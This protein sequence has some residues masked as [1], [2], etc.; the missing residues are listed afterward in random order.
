MEKLT[1][2][3]LLKKYKSWLSAGEIQFLRKGSPAQR[4]VLIHITDLINVFS[5]A[6]RDADRDKGEI[7]EKLDWEDTHKKG[8][9]LWHE[10]ASHSLNHINSDSKGN[11]N[12][13]DF[14]EAATEFED[15]LYGLEHYYRDHTLHSLW[16]YFLGEYILRELLPDIHTNLNWYLFNDIERN[17]SD[18]SK[19]LVDKASKREKELNKEI[20]KHKD[21]TWCLMALCHDLGYS[22]AKFDKLNEKVKTV[23]NFFDLPDFKHIGYSLDVEHQYLVK[24]FLELMAID[25]R[26]VPN[27]DQKEE[28]IKCYRD[29]ATYWQ[30]CRALEKKQHGI[31]SSY[32][33]FKIL[34]I[35]ADTSV[36][37]PAEEWG[38]DDDEVIE[39]VIRGDILFGI[40]Q[41]TFDFAY[42][43]QLGSLAEILILADELEEFSR[44]GRKMLSRKY[45]DTMAETKISFH[46]E[47]PKIGED[48]DIHITYEV[49]EHHP[50][51]VF[52]KRKAEQLCKTYSLEQYQQGEKYCSIKSIKLTAEKKGEKY[53]FQLHR[54]SKKNR[55]YLPKTKINGKEYK[56]AEYPL[57]C[58]DDKIYHITSKGQKISFDEWFQNIIID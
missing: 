2:L 37:G 58:I 14:L 40:A 54:D 44:Y 38:L 5:K 31:L 28:L 33:I 34:G 3:A 35:F 51:N 19:K 29:D 52:Y 26:I 15:L 1:V 36:R 24:Q 46:P 39:N 27:T 16:V 20:N 42:L 6:E 30:L 18:Y 7:S 25:V 17:Q 49:S 23:L 12:L 56:E 47:K 4:D 22:L 21:A 11:S 55:G 9:D 48:I 10:L 50:L 41:H 8:R 57:I 53:S 32:L 13:F 43:N 45:H